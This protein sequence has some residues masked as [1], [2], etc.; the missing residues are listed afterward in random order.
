MEGLDTVK[1][2]ETTQTVKALQNYQ[3]GKYICSLYERQGNE[4]DISGDPDSF[5]LTFGY[6][7][8]KYY[9]EAY[10]VAARLANK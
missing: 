7:I 2:E 4:I 5:Y 1:R 10:E 8:E 9:P 6:I 3:V